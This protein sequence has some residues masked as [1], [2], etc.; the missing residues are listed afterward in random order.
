MRLN[1]QIILVR[2]VLLCLLSTNLL[3]QPFYFRPKA[4]SPSGYGDSSG[5][6]YN[7]AWHYDG[8]R[9]GVAGN[10]GLE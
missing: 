6:T 2:S 10:P 8:V 1:P 9:T 7:D 3:A 4:E 5:E